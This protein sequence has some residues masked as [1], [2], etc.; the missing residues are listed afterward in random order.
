MAPPR[1]RMTTQAFPALGRPARASPACREC[2]RNRRGCTRGNA[3]SSPF[4]WRACPSRGV[5][6]SAGDLQHVLN[7]AVPDAVADQIEE[8]DIARCFPELFQEMGALRRRTVEA[9]KVEGGQGL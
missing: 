5:R 4:R 8:A 1:G 7:E 3:A 9:A 2:A 6:R